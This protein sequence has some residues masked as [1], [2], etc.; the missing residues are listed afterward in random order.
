MANQL[1]ILSFVG[2]QQHARQTKL[3][4]IA[5]PHFTS[6]ALVMMRHSVPIQ[7]LYNVGA[8]ATG[9]GDGSEE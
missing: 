5:S 4:C 9:Y 1:F 6:I 8:K 2:W 7:N 3:L